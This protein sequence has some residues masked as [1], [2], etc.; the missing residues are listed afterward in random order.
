[1]LLHPKSFVLG[2]SIILI[3]IFY[4]LVIANV[5]P[6]HGTLVVRIGLPIAMIAGALLLGRRPPPLAIVGAAVIVVTL[7]YVI[8]ITDGQARWMLAFWGTLTGTFMVVRGLASEFHPWNRAA[9]TVREKMRI[10]GLVVLMASVLSLALTALASVAIAAGLLPATALVPTVS[11]LLHVPTI[12]LGT[13]CGGAMLTA[14]AYL[15]FSSV[16]KIN[17]ENLTAML[18]FA[19][20]TAWIF[21]VIGVSAGLIV[22]ESLDPRLIVA[23]AVLVAAVLLIFWAGH[24]ARARR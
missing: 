13:L 9:R 6:A 7:A 17:T 3:E 11:Q 21:Q 23:M 5:S 4:Y 2:F 1:M 22:A 14:M 16:V 19:P 12:L 24:R 10:T 18:A 15:G 20:V 8:A